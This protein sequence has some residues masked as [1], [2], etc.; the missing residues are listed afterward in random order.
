MA[1]VTTVVTVR[2]SQAD[3]QRKTG[4]TLSWVHLKL[5]SDNNNVTPQPTFTEIGQ[6]Q[7]K[8]SYDATAN[9]EAAGQID[10]GNT[11]TAEGDRY[12]DVL[13][14]VPAYTG[15]PPTADAIAD[16]VAAALTIPTAAQNAAETI[17]EFVALVWSKSG[18]TQTLKDGDGNTLGTSG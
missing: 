6:G 1:V 17:A 9:G 8:F 16:A 3:G 7:Y 12:I 10:A 14:T 11:L 4:L 13:L 5:L 18:S 2:D 15:T